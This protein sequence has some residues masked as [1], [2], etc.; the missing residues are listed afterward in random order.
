MPNFNEADTCRK[1]ILPNL[2]AAGWNDDQISEQKSFTDGRIL[3]VGNKARRRPCKRADY[4]LRYARDFMIAV[5]EAK[6]AYKSPGDGLQQAKEYA[7]ILGL[8]FAYSTNGHGIIEFDS[9]TGQER[10]LNAFPAPDEL[11]ARLRDRQGLSDE[12]TKR[13]LTPSYHLTD[14]SPRYYQEI[15]INRT[16]QSILQGKWRILLTM[17]TGA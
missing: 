1:Y 9:L 13:L 4:L 16:V 5:V 17:A 10:F 14:K 8:K 11:W 2:Y 6:A 15:A 12:G 7:E 3:V